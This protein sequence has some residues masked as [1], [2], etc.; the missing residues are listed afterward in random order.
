MKGIVDIDIFSLLIS[1]AIMLIPIAGF[2]YYRVPLIKDTAIGLVRM[3]V[4]LS[5]VAIYLE[6]IFKLNS[7]YLNSFWVLIMILVGVQ[8]SI[9]RMHLDFRLFIVPF[10]ISGLTSLIIIDAFFLGIIIRPENV[11][12]ARYFV[13][14]SGM[15]LGNAMNH[16]IVGLSTYL[17]GL[18]SNRELYYFL[19][20]NGNNRAVAVMPFIRDGLKRALNPLIAT[21]SVMGLISLPGMMTGQ[22]LG[23][24]SPAVAIK[25]QIMIMLAIFAGC[26]INLLFSIFFSNRFIFDAYD[27]LK[28]NIFVAR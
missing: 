11:F 19:L 28:K 10:I 5:L 8:T 1:F 6:Y 22:I 14:I 27:R 3:S 13:P 2:L 21:M 18:N 16:N 23:G 24:S 26:S 12:D 9:K 7:P 17:D 20:V 15:I 25:Y 4:Q